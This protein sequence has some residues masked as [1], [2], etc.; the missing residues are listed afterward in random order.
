MLSIIY[1]D[2]VALFPAD[3]RNGGNATI[4]I[5]GPNLHIF[6]LCWAFGKVFEAHGWET[7]AP[8]MDM[9]ML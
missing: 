5:I 3:S 9:E 7:A 8:Y 2:L 6:G 4:Q 1:M